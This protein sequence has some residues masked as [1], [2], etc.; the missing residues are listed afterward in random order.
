MGAAARRGGCRCLCRCH[1]L[2]LLLLLL[3]L[4]LQEEQQHPLASPLHL[5]HLL[6]SAAAAHPCPAADAAAAAPSPLGPYGELLQ[7]ERAPL[8]WQGLESGHQGSAHE[9]EGDFSAWLYAERERLYFFDQHGPLCLARLFYGASG[10]LADDAALRFFERAVLHVEVDGAAALAAPA[11][12][13][14]NGSLSA[15]LPAALT[16]SLPAVFARGGN[17]LLAP[18]CAHQRLRLAWQFPLSDAR[19]ASRVPGLHVNT[20]AQALA[21]A[22]ECVAQGSACFLKV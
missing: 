13:L 6:S 4:W 10:E 20:S 1:L 17:V 22:D 7:L 14:F 5:R 12:A 9:R 8:L 21:Q 16:A 15:L 11:E 18:L 2:L 3:T 19:A